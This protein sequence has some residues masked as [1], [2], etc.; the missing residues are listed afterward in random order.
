MRRYIGGFLLATVL[1]IPAAISLR[2][3]DDDHAEHERKEHRMKRYYDPDARDYHEWNEREDRAWRRY[4][5]ERH[6]NYHDW[7]RATKAE[8]RAYWRWRHEHADE[9]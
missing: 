4:W 9:R 7:A 1:A 6:E 2:A 8:Q 3:D 5:E